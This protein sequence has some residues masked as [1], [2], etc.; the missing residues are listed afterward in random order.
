VLHQVTEATLRVFATM[1]KTRDSSKFAD[2]PK[3]SGT[4]VPLPAR[5]APR[6]PATIEHRVDELLNAH[7]KVNRFSGAALIAS[8]GKPLVA[9]GYGY[10]NST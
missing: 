7:M 10:A 6:D 5:P 1:Q 2:P 8:Q 9:K 4:V 3:S